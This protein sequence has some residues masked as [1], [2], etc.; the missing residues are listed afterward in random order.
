M[1]VLTAALEAHEAGLC[2]VP[3][4]Q[5][6]TKRPDG[7]WKA[8]QRH[9]PTE[10]TIQTWYR[11]ETRTGLGIICGEVSGGLEMLELEGRA[12]IEGLADRL[13]DEAERMGIAEL[14]ERIANGYCER[15]PSGGLHLLYRC[16]EISG[17][18]KLARRTATDDELATNP[19]ERIKVLI[20][21]RG[22][23]GY[24]I[25]APSN[26][27]V[28]PNGAGWE[29]VS[30]G[31]NAIATITPD[32]R[33]SLLDLCRQF[34]TVP[35][36]EAPQPTAPTEPWITAT[37]EST[38][39]SEE[40]MAERS[41]KD[42]LERAGF[43]FH[44]EDGKGLHYT[45]PGKDLREGTS[46]TI[47][48][49]NGKATL[50]SSSI[51]APVEALGGDHNYNAWQLHVMLNYAGDFSQAAREWRADHPRERTAG[52]PKAQEPINGV[53]DDDD[54]DWAPVDLVDIARKML[55]GEIERT[56]PTVLCVRNALPLF[57]EGR[58]NSLFG[59]SGGGKTW[60]AI[61]AIAEVSR[62]GNRSLFVDYEDAPNGAVERFLA[63]GMTLEEIGL[64]EYANPV[65]GIGYGLAALEKRANIGDFRLAV[66]D[67]T[68]EAMAAGGT[69]GNDDPSTRAWFKILKAV[70]AR[71]N[72]PAIIVLDHTVKAKDAPALFAS[73][74]QAKRAAITGAS[75]RVDTIKEPAKGKDGQIKIT[76]AKDRFGNRSKGSTAAIVDIRSADDNVTIELHLSEAQEA[77]ARGEAF[78][79]T[80][81][82]ERVSRFVEI[83]PGATKR[84]TEEGVTGKGEGIRQAIDV[85]SDEGFIDLQL[86]TKKGSI[87][88]YSLRSYRQSDD[89]RAVDNSKDQTPR[90]TASHR[91]PTASQDEVPTA[92]PRPSP[93]RGDGDEDAVK[94]ATARPPV[95]NPMP[96]L[97]EIEIPF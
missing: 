91:V 89:P 9:R 13:D 51:D 35:V 4:R 59:E 58:I 11:D 3:P 42:V 64:V 18:E 54:D 1:N 56:T 7:L 43:A 72:G 20:E 21:T 29:L 47:W 81:L 66:I 61:A 44:H 8:Y 30:G 52:T 78:R 68:G 90:P 97:E 31:F 12:V 76:V 83:N 6:G 33:R 32:E 10:Q 53:V 41:A 5:D 74:S 93:Y 23:G 38:M 86:G 45:R 34:D 28:H 15:T 36:R 46:A 96:A 63:L 71:L 82:M 92:S 60:I 49:D 84:Q 48:S 26:G 85:L 70:S 87:E 65:R 2:V 27:N 16:A 67:S 69:D 24:V 79:P 19:A 39:P 22:E 80:V 50:F 88:L 73:G 75:Y 40:F 62:A 14:L 37:G 25:V 57:Y 55:A 95:D 77:I 17:N 94:D